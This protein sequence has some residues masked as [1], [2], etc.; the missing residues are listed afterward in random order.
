MAGLHRHSPRL[1]RRRVAL[2]LTHQEAT[3]PS[4]PVA[5]VPRETGHVTGAGGTHIDGSPP[6]WPCRCEHCVL[7]DH[8]DREA[9]GNGS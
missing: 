3:P 1:V 6:G 4:G 2:A 7:A 8:S 9:C 5:D